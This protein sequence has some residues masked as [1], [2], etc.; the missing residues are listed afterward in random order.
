MQNLYQRVK[1]RH[2]SLITSTYLPTT[3]KTMISYIAAPGIKGKF[4][5]I[6]TLGNSQYIAEHVINTVSNY[7]RIDRERVLGKSRLGRIVMCR[8]IIHWYLLNKGMQC[9]IVGK[10]FG[11]DH[12]T[13]LHSR[14]V[15]N[16]MLNA[17]YDNEYKTH[18][19]NL[20]V[21]I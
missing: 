2:A 4:T 12:S 19:E 15:I 20:N 9:T 5:T 21:I 13:V 11:K 16:D 3:S 17:S 8:Q 14:K 6:A 1:S 18:I 7:F 10:I